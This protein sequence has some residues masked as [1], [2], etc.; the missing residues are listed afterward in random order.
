MGPGSRF[1]SAAFTVTLLAMTTPAFAQQP[2]RSV[3]EPAPNWNAQIAGGF[4]L[5][6]TGGLASAAIGYTP[7]PRLTLLLAIERIY[8][9]REARERP[10]RGATTTFGELEVR[11]RLSAADRV[12]PYALVAYGR[13]V[14]S[15]KE[16]AISPEY[17]TD[18]RFMFLIGGGVHVPIGRRLAAFADV[19]VGPKIGP[20]DVL[21]PMVP[22]RGG[23]AWRF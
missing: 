11:V 14:S 9:P 20:Y 22:V 8:L 13:G 3:S 7:L 12:S 1:L 18:D 10:G 23:L 16:H 2:G 17:A 5:N 19:R 15:G 21:A 6:T 4:H